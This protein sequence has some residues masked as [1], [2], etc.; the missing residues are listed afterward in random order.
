MREA[1]CRMTRR[2]K[3]LDDMQVH[4]ACQQTINMLLEEPGAQSGGAQDPAEFAQAIYTLPRVPRTAS[5][6]R[7]V[8][9]VAR[10][11][12]RVC[13]HRLSVPR[14]PDDFH[15]LWEC[16]MEGEPR[17][18]E[19][20]PS[21]RFRERAGCIRNGKPPYDVLQI[22]ADPADY[23]A[24]L[25]YLLEFAHD[26]SFQPE[27]RAACAFALFEWIH[28]FADGNGHTGRALMLALVQ[29]GYSLPTM[30]CFSTALAFGKG[31]TSKLFARLRTCEGTLVDFCRG[32]LEQLKAAQVHS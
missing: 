12:A 25:K 26:E 19:S 22:C 9:E 31:R 30:V 14:Q 8:R 4:F 27:I 11:Y 23:P 32:T 10:M 5:N 17:W 2:M 7:Q 18:S 29:G 16:A 21:S 3:Q 6:R 20:H 1:D 28:P 15:A 13:M 24:E